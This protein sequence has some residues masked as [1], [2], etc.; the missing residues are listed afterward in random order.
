MSCCGQWEKIVGRDFLTFPPLFNNPSIFW[1]I[2]FWKKE[3]NNNPVMKNWYSCNFFN[4][5][6]P[7]G[8]YEQGRI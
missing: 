3:G 4:I 2:Y 8:S 7:L 1:R 5:G 6:V